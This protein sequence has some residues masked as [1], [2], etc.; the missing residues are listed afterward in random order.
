MQII[1]IK[2]NAYQEMSEYIG[3]MMN[4][5]MHGPGKLIYENGEYYTGDFKNGKRYGEGE[6]GKLNNLLAFLD[7][8]LVIDS[9]MIYNLYCEV[10]NSIIPNSFSF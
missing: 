9:T 2:N 5:M 6:Y 1:D 10:H 8:I 4:G 7:I 3:K